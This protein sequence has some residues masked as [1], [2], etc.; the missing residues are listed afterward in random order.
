MTIKELCKKY[1]VSSG[2]WIVEDVEC[3]G[4]LGIRRMIVFGNDECVDIGG[5]Y[6]YG[7]L[8][9]ENGNP[10]YDKLYHCYYSIEGNEED[11]GNID[12]S[13]PCY[14]EE[15]TCW[16]DEWADYS[17]PMTEEE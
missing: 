17:E 14:V 10:L 7:V 5:F 4:D 8:V 2:K 13:S 15:V 1:G 12:Y 6:Q 11:W 9:D 16:Y 3:K